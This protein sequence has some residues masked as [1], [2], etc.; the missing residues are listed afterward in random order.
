MTQYGTRL[1]P[2]ALDSHSEATPNRLYASVSRSANVSDGFQDITCEDMARC[3]NFMAHWIVDHFG[4]SDQFDTLA[5]VGIPD[6]RSAA[7][8][9]GAVKAGYKVR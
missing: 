6:L 3:V 5:Y 4:A 8:F 1:M 9:L 2:Q 7:V